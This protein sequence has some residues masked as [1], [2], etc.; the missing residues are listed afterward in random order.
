MTPHRLAAL[1]LTALVAA[2]AFADPSLDTL[3]ARATAVAADCGAAMEAVAP[4]P[5]PSVRR[6][7]ERS[8]ARALARVADARSALDAGGAA[9]ARRALA[10]AARTAAGARN[11][12]RRALRRLDAGRG[13]WH[14]AL[15]DLPATLYSVW[16]GPGDDPWIVAS[17]AD[18]GQGPLLF[19]GRGEG[20]VRIPVPPG[21]DL[22]WIDEIPGAGLWACGAA[23]R[24]VRYDPA[25]GALDEIPTGALGT[26]YGLWG[27]SPDE[28][29]TVGVGPGD[30][31]PLLFRWDGAKWTRLPAPPEVYG[32]ALFKVWGRAADDVWACGSMGALLH[33]D[34]AAW[35]VVPTGV[36]TALLTVH[37]G[38]AVGEVL[39][40]AI[41]ERGA[42][43]WRPVPLP[44]AARS[45]AGVWVPDRGAPW[46]VG[47]FGSVA[48][49]T[50]TAGAVRW[51]VVRDVPVP[52]GHDLHA[53]RVDGPGGAWIAGGDLI[54]RIDGR[55][56]HHGP[57]R[58]RDPEA[59]RYG[60]TPFAFVPDWQ[61]DVRP[62]FAAACAGSGCHDEPPIASVHPG[63]PSVGAFGRV[64]AG[65][66]PAAP[67]ALTTSQRATLRAWVLGGALRD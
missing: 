21:G 67:V 5:R 48:R 6:S 15:E 4:V 45:F 52:E 60:P 20:F 22:W 31:K 58:V 28:V 36:E 23:G 17:G 30:E 62:V 2:A 49:R 50:G 51:E 9:S 14:V 16:T 56:L 42:G 59:P 41:V 8:V 3:E 26:L 1:A 46:A 63:R 32:R 18:D 43:G 13:R 37:Q 35:S 27:A 54:A 47:Y 65:D 25:T 34:G 64:L 10:T 53:V 24:V 44:P 66:H 19:R 29:W 40:A 39:S 11:R 55:L 33:Y 7:V 38:I 61:T 57:R 12:A